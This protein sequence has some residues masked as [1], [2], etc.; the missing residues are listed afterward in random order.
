MSEA[1]ETNLA[2]NPF[3][4][5][6]KLRLDQSY[7]DSAGVKKLLTTVPV[8]KPSP[9]DWIRVH[10][11][12]RYRLTPAAII[13]LKEDREAYLLTPNVAPELPGE[14]KVVT[15]FTAIN[16]QGVLRVWHIPL[17]GPDGKYNEWHR[18]AAEAAERAMSRWVRVKA[19]MSLGAND[20]FEAIGDIPD[21]EWP[22]MSFEEILQ[23]AFRDKIVDKSDHPLIRR[24]RGAA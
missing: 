11:D 9:Q 3:G 22:G 18:S 15:L 19:N 6:S 16:R 23:V 12:P 10:P 7:A 17:P 8:G 1:I 24:L 20:I 14:F 2:A 13:D 21:P 4:D 5:L